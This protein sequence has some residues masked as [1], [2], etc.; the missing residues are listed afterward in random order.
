MNMKREIFEELN[1]LGVPANLLG[2]KYIETAIELLVTDPDM[3]H[4]VM[5]VLYPSIARDY[6]ATAKNVER[7]IRHAI[8]VSWERADHDTLR[9]YFGSTVNV[10][11]KPTNSEY[12]CMVARRVAL[13]GGEEAQG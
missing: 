4:K 2:R 12:L 8:E 7:G 1:R 5:K 3:G 6:H 13:R 10:K 11:I 9:A